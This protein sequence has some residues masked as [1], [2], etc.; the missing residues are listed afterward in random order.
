MPSSLDLSHWL[1]LDL[2]AT[3]LSLTLLAV[4]VIAITAVFLDSRRRPSTTLAWLLTLVFLP[5]IGVLLFLLLGT[6]R[7]RRVARRSAAIASRVSAVLHE[8]GI[9]DKLSGVG[10]GTLPT[11]TEAMLRLGERLATTPASQGNSVHLLNNGAATYRAIIRAIESATDHIHVEFYIIQPDPTGINL[12]DRLVRR[13]AEGITV[14]VLVDAVGSRSLPRSFWEPLR[15]AGGNAAIFR[16]VAKLLYRLRRRDRIDFRN[17]RKIV[18][19]DGRVGFTGGINVGR[20]YLGLDPNIG[21]WRDTHLELCGPAVL[22]LQETFAEDWLTATDQLLDEARYFP[23]PSDNCAG[24]CVVQVVDSGPDRTWS[25]IALLFIQAM[26]MA[27]KRLWITNPYFIPSAPIET[28][29]VSA[30]LRGVDVC[31]LLPKR[32]GHLLI[33]L[34]SRSYYEALL[35]AG[36]RIFHY[37]RGFIHAKTFVVDD[38]MATVGSANMDMRSFNLN[39]EL[40]AFVYH[41]S[42]ADKLAEQFRH[43]LEGATEIDAASH[44]RRGYTKRLVQSFSRLMSP[45]L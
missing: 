6:T 22:S 34:A 32:A 31:L 14:R 5:G 38:W 7:L 43:D 12:R 11:R 25:S 24:D 41:G 3:A 28:A 42:F 20:E 44:A 15:A 27:R 45:L 4:H 19:V 33:T 1:G 29:L 30:G 9:N 2:N 18:V 17:H 36:V 37:E 23:D 13:A 39:F 21:A 35:E 10:D 16:P 8:H 26:A 40:N